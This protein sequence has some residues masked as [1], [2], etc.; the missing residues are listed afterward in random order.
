MLEGLFQEPAQ[1]EVN[2]VLD[3]EMKN[4]ARRR[5]QEQ[6]QQE[7]E[8]QQQQQDREAGGAGGGE[9]G[10]GAGEQT[11]EESLGGDSQGQGNSTQMSEVERVHREVAKIEK[12]RRRRRRRS[13]KEKGIE[14][15][16]IPVDLLRRLAALFAKHKISRDAAAEITAGFYR[17]C[18][19]DLEDVILS[20]TT[21]Q[22]SRVEE[23]KMIQEKAMKNLKAKVEEENLKLTLH[24]DTKLMKQRMAGVRSQMERLALVVS[25]PGLERPQVVGMLALEGGTALEQ[26][27]AA[28]AVLEETGLGP[29]VVDLCYDTTATNTGRHGGTVRLLQTMAATTM[30]TS[31][32]RR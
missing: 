18:D 16:C 23:S 20:P 19:V 22:R 24:Y 31:P 6:Q 29:H 10:A 11:G 28:H 1:R 25:A 5:F 26:A 13:Q 8:Q 17:E 2:V 3:I 7:Q 32:C 14:G 12:E 30:S 4:L 9:G 21:S 15:K 27:T